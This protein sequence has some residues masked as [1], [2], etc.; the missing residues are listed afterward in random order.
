ME[1]RLKDL[2]ELT[3]AVQTRIAIAAAAGLVGLLGVA[4]LILSR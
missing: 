1:R 2:E 3:A 4:A